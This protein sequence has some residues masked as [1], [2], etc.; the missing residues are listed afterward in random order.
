MLTD[1]RFCIRYCFPDTQLEE[2]TTEN[3]TLARQ[4]ENSLADTRRLSEDTREKAAY[5]VCV[6]KCF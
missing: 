4:L 5:K 2:R 1:I 6:V 3:S